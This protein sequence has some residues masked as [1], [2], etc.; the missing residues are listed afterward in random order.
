MNFVSYT[1]HQAAGTQFQFVR[2]STRWS[3]CRSVHHR[4]YI[5]IHGDAN[6]MSLNDGI[7]NPWIIEN[8]RGVKMR[9]YRASS[10]PTASF[11]NSDNSTT[12]DLN[13]IMAV[14]LKNSPSKTENK[15]IKHLISNVRER[16]S[17]LEKQYDNTKN[18]MAEMK[19]LL[20]EQQ[21]HIRMLQTKEAE[22]QIIQSYM[23]NNTN[24]NNSNN[25]GANSNNNSSFPAKKGDSNSNDKKNNNANNIDKNSNCPE[26][27]NVIKEK[28]KDHDGNTKIVNNIPADAVETDNIV[29]L[30]DKTN[31]DGKIKNLEKEIEMYKTKLKNAS[32]MFEQ[33][34]KSTNFW[35]RRAESNADTITHLEKI[36][37]QQKR[38][39]KPLVSSGRRTTSHTIEHSNRHKKKGNGS[40]SNNKISKNK[41]SSSRRSL[42]S[43][44]GSIELNLSWPPLSSSSEEEGNDAE[45]IDND[46]YLQNDDDDIESVTVDDLKDEDVQNILNEGEDEVSTL[47]ASQED[48]FTIIQKFYK[49]DTQNKEE[50]Q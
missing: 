18:V 6:N 42:R 26:K 32:N 11:R 21:E 36:I 43:I 47:T 49:D 45:E 24:N 41:K 38:M 22:R 23:D 1:H 29:P 28:N 12:E 39:I 20:L 19:Q 25:S 33:E 3:D 44:E 31:M 8:K 2:Y 10:P 48:S 14:S 13:E 37:Q 34:K 46:E 35:K 15:K 4:I 16:M 40:N 17:T 50:N 30:I 5:Y 7:A 9:A 27:S